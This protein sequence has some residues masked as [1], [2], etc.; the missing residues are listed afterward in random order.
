MVFIFLS[1]LL[2]NDLS[3]IR[4]QNVHL[5][6]L[7]VEVTQ[8]ARTNAVL[9]FSFMTVFFTWSPIAPINLRDKN[10]DLNLVRKCVSHFGR[11]CTRL[12][13]ILGKVPN[14]NNNNKHMYYKDRS[15]HWRPKNTCR[16]DVT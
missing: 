4:T 16:I 1:F 6:P 11:Q 8:R 9:A 5:H 15:W 7:P 12:R 3:K 14:K 10:L 13:A 2:T